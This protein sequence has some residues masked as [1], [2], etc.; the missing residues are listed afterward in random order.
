MDN[1][2]SPRFVLFIECAT[3][4]ICR[5]NEYFLSQRLSSSYHECAN[6]SISHQNISHQ[7]LIQN[8]ELQVE[9]AFLNLRL[10]YSRSV[11]TQISIE[12]HDSAIVDV[13]R[14]ILRTILRLLKIQVQRLHFSYVFLFRISPTDYCQQLISVDAVKESECAAQH[15]LLV[16]AWSKKSID[17]ESRH[18]G[19]TRHI[20]SIQENP[21][22]LSSFRLQIVHI[23]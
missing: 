3:E 12:E 4:T 14:I 22:R 19:K 10:W 2:H 18:S 11:L 15:P 23:V 5:I 20:S 21:A 7:Y 13:V 8:H 17:Y 1:F 6:K 9:I 16:V